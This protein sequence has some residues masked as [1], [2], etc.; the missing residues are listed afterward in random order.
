M[1]KEYKNPEV[2]VEETSN[3]PPSINAVETAIPA[4]IGYTQKAQKHQVGDLAFVPTRI[5]SLAEY[6]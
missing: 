3:L 5:T 2:Y 6:E 4:F 1:S